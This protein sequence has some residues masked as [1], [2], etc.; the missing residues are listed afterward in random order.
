MSV[1][2]EFRVDPDQFTLG[3]V[4]ASVDGLRAEIERIVPTGNEALPFFWAIGECFDELEERLFEE[5]SI[6]E[7]TVL[8][9]VGDSV[10]YRIEWTDPHSGII[11]GISETGGT[12]LQARGNHEWL[13]RL[14]FPNHDTVARFHNYCQENDITITIDRLFTLTKDADIGHEFDLTP[15]QREAIVL[16]VRRG[17]FATPKEVSLAELAAELDIS[18]QAV[19]AR[20]RGA[21]E[22]ILENVLLSSADNF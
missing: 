18:Q 8:D 10:L 19:S 22:K 13:F 17:Y 16:A 2:V 6:A 14:R 9:R 3:R 12:I 7:F 4:V 20:V 1:I 21:N 5:P 11:D 15:E